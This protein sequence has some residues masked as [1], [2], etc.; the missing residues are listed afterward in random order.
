MSVLRRPCKHDD[1]LNF[2][3]KRLFSIGGAPAVRL[4][5]GRYGIARGEWR[6]VAAL[7]EGGP[8]SPSELHERIGGDRAR[9]SRVVTGLAEKGLIERRLDAGDKRRATLLV[10]DPGRA[11]YSELFPQ[12]A[13]INERL[14][15][16]L[17]DRDA[18]LLDEF[19]AR[20]TEQARK[21][22]LEGDGV[23]A[24]ADRRHGGSRSVWTERRSKEQA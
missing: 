15:A 11:L 12:L 8:Q 17:D 18:A 6:I 24:R 22:Q 7:C 1:L 21:L 13:G 9:T 3:L 4:C 5:E 16:V 2:R 23:D 19:L 14:M 20:L 10:T